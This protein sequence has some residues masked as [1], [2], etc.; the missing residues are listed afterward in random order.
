MDA[1]LTPIRLFRPGA[2]TSSEGLKLSF[3]E[4]DL[5]ASAAAYDA[6]RDP[7]PLVIGHPR[8]NDPAYGWVD[9]L[10]VEDGELV[11]VPARVDASFAETVR[12]GRYARVSAQFYLPDD[13]ANP[14][15]GT[16]Y[17]RHVG[18]LGAQA[19]AVKGLGTVSFSDAAG[20][21][22]IEIPKDTEDGLT[23]DIEAQRA[24]FAEAE[25]ALDA[26]ET[27]IAAREKAAEE[28]ARAARHQ[29]HASFA[30]E[31]V[32]GGRLA[33]A[34]MALVIG[35]L[36]RLAETPGV[37][38]FAEAGE[39]APA[40]ALRKLLDTATPL[41]SFAELAAPEGGEDAVLASFAAPAGFSVSRDAAEAYARAKAVQ[42]EHPELS[43]IEAARRAGA[44]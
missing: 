24:S 44:R 6:A 33:P 5:A 41:I 21:A 20:V 43:I 36:D 1:A 38:S 40:D 26:R 23:K 25:R 9:S 18:F 16:W 12:A 32:K 3:S 42:A 28:A 4:A 10:R 15:P 13:P 37:A 14:A 22:T 35:L 11:A 17:L 8:I 39:L 7:A 30:E 19:P 29:G 31:M 2:F 34:G 27:Q